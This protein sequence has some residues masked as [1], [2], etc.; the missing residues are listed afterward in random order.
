MLQ[1]R[2][3]LLGVGVLVGELLLLRLTGSSSSPRLKNWPEFKLLAPGT[4]SSLISPD[5]PPT[6]PDPALPTPAAPAPMSPVTA[7]GEL[8]KLS[9]SECEDL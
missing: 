3:G 2:P 4:W 9:K 1:A 5:Y 8:I 7:A 6:P